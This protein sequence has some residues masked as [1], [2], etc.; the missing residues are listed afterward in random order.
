MVAYP[1]VRLSAFY[2]VYF[3]ILGVLLPFWPL[4]LSEVGLSVAQIGTLMAVLMLTRIV[5][6]FLWGK[7]GDALENRMRV[8]QWGSVA[9][10][11]CFAGVFWAQSF[12]WLVL[13]V[14]GYSFFW[15]AILPQFEVVTLN[16]LGDAH[17]H[18][19]RVRAWGSVGFI[20][21]A[22]G[23]GWYFNVASI[24]HVPFILAACFIALTIL[25]WTIPGLVGVQT[26]KAA[27]PR[28]SVLLNSSFVHC[29]AQ[30]Y[31]CFLPSARL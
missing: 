30:S 13:V 1:H 17:H 28:L 31:A 11:L 9:A 2:A 7:L 25:S 6:P 26:D 18:Y 23:L 21:A 20:G 16:Y 4:Y 10:A 3:A 22:V 27:K 29:I 24:M 19:S 5:S 12:E 8:I 15:N 14:A